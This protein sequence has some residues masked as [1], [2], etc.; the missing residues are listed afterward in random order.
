[1]KLKQIIDDL[2]DRKIIR[3]SISPYCSRVV[4]VNKR[5]GEK[6]MCIDLRPLNKIVQK[7]RYTFPVIEDHLNKLYEKK[8][9]Y[10]LRFEGRLLSD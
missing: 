9:I 5:N 8:T 4:L 3:P 10:K 6:R 7:Q 2:L 1:M